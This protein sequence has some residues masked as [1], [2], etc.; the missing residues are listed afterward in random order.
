M[1]RTSR[2]DVVVVGARIAG[3]LTAG[4]FARRGL[5]VLLVDRAQLPSPT[6][7][8]HFFRGGGLLDVL[9]RLGW[10]PDVEG[11]GAPRL[12]R[13]YS[14]ADGSTHATLEPP[15]EPGDLGFNMSVRREAIDGVLLAAAG[16]DGADVRTETAVVDLVRSDGGRVSGVVLEDATSVEAGLVVGADGRRSRVAQLV[17]AEDR[18]RFPGRRALYYR[19]VSGFP[20]PG[21]TAPDGPEFSLLGDEL[22]YV[23]PSD[24]GLTCLAVSVNLA[25]YERMRREP[26]TR[27][28]ELMRR[29]AGL[30]QRYADAEPAGRLY[31]A[32]PA[33]DW[34]RCPAGPGW[35]L[36]GDSGLHQDP[37][38]GAGMDCAA[39]SAELL[40]SAYCAAGGSD[41]WQGTYEQSRAD[42]LLE[43]FHETVT[44]AED[45]A[46]ALA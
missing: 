14:Y 18:E 25:E 43:V 17:G 9:D 21:G 45:L 41:A 30:W 1:G 20:G 5:R 12:T 29:H 46:A 22:A 31:G 23:F 44:G 7:S 36:V 11:L 32:P 38:S 13:E 33:P 16:R 42:R 8:T 3:S 39:L 19:Y 2:F 26:R 6:L 4:L 34:L 15:Q 40:V 28:D 37:W 27:F 24:A 10:L 35:A